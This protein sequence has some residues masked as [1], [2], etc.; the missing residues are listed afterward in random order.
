MLLLM[1]FKLLCARQRSLTAHPPPIHYPFHVHLALP[2][3]PIKS[4]NVLQTPSDLGAALS[5]GELHWADLAGESVSPAGA[6]SWHLWSDSRAQ[7][8]ARHHCHQR[9]CSPECSLWSWTSSA[10][11]SAIGKS[12]KSCRSCHK[13]ELYGKLGGIQW[14][15]RGVSGANSS[16]VKANGDPGGSEHRSWPSSVSCESTSQLLA[17]HSINKYIK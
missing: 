1:G 8:S 16:C 2:P 13:R 6:Q 4:P 3:Q 7:T 12:P 5:R 15:Q 10:R 11:G 14:T 17:N 9:R